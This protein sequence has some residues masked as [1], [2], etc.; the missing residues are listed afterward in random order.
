MFI[1]SILIIIVFGN[2][3]INNLNGKNNSLLHNVCNRFL[4]QVIMRLENFLIYVKGTPSALLCL[5]GSH[6][7]LLHAAC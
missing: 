2:M 6:S 4:S 1:F 5:S 7:L 3:G